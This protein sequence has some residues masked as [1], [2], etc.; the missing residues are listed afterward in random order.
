MRWWTRALVP[1]WMPA[2]SASKTSATTQTVGDVGEGNERPV[3]LDNLRAAETF[4]STTTPSRGAKMVNSLSPPVTLR[5]PSFASA[6]RSAT[7]ACRY[8]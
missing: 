4:F 7:D 5:L 2:A 3:G 6:A 8:C 1:A